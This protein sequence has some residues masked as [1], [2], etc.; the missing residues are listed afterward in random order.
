MNLGKDT[1]QCVELPM[2][3][4]ERLKRVFDASSP[5]LPEGPEPEQAGV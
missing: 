4:T 3:R 2:I 1:V 5:W